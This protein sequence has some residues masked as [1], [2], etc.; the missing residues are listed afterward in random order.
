MLLMLDGVKP[1][2]VF[3]VQYPVEPDDYQVDALFEPHVRSGLLVKRVIDEPFD[4]PVRSSLGR[5]F[6]GVRRVFYARRGEEWRIDA[7]IL[8][9]KQFDHGA[10]NETMERLL[11]SLL[12]YTDE[13]NNWWLG[14]RRR[15]HASPV[16][17][18]STVYIAV[19]AAELTWMRAV[20]E[21]ALQPERSEPCLELVMPDYRPDPAAL[22]RWL[23]ESDSAAI[24]RFGVPRSFFTGRKI[25]RRGDGRYYCM[26]KA[27]NVLALNRALT[28]SIDIVAERAS[29]SSR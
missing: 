21:R 24:L 11:G 17:P 8:L 1:F 20:G 18:D 9:W 16:W 5:R 2:A 12:G 28:T 13:Q 23:E 26:I 25:E 3:P 19:D 7:H 22:Q 4:K 15:E 27:E 10:W 14:R 6:D 29:D